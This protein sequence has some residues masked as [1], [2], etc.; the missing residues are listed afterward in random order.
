MAHN[1]RD[2]EGL[3]F[4]YTLPNDQ[5]PSDKTVGTAALRL[6]TQN[7]RRLKV[8]F[9]NNGTDIVVLGYDASVTTNTGIPVPPG[10]IAEFDWQEDYEE[11]TR[12]FW[13]VAATAGNSVHI[14]EHIMTGIDDPGVAA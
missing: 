13:G 8:R 3:W 4:N 6:V 10:Q 7:A 14:T 5:V 11:V 2:L 1:V 9:A 12:E